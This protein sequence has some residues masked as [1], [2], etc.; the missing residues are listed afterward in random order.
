MDAYQKPKESISDD[1]TQSKRKMKTEKLYFASIDDTFCQP[2][3]YF[4]HDA[5]IESRK[6][7]RLIEAIP[8]NNNPDYV[9]CMQMGEVAERGLCRKSECSYYQSKSGRGVCSNRGSLYEHGDEVT[10]KISD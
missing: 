4:I 8:D 5:K 6:E 3:E 10:F 9:W 2:L 7:I 1:T